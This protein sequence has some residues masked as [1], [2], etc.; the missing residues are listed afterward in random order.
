VA[1]TIVV[2]QRNSLVISGKL[3]TFMPEDPL[4]IAYRRGEQVSAEL[5]QL[6]EAHTEFIQSL[7]TK[8]MAITKAVHELTRKAHKSVAIRCSDCVHLLSLVTNCGRAHT[9]TRGLTIISHLRQQ[10]G[11]IRPQSSTHLIPTCKRICAH[12]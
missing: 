6:P 11:S 2:L 5:A 3:P 1:S 12:A 8:N 10:L 7:S 9:A 4:L